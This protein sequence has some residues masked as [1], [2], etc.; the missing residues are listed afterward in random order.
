MKIIFIADAHLK[1]TTDPNQTSLAMFIDGLWGEARPDTLVLLGDIFDFWTGFNPI[2]YD[3]HLP[4]LESLEALFS[5]GVDIVYIEGNHDF[6]M[7]T[8]FTSTLGA[9]V[10]ADNCRLSVDGKEFFIAHGDA[11]SMGFG[12]AMW[13]AF[14]RGRLFRVI[15]SL[16]SPKTVVRVADFLSKRSRAH[17]SGGSEAI[18]SRLREFAGRTVDSGF[19]VVVLGHSHCPGVQ[20]A[21]G[22]EGGVG[23]VGERRGVYANPGSWID[24]SYLVYENGEMRVERMEG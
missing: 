11:V 23:V 4:I 10:H 15:K 9:E 19:D 14:L 2:V 13:R 3:R 22:G 6:N 5:R 20:S 8:F 17:M 16:L 24:G 1:G 21:G 7:G 12:Y 18:D